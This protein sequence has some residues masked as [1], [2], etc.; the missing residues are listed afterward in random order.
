MYFLE[1]SISLQQ[2]Q[3]LLVFP[4]KID[5]VEKKLSFLMNTKQ[6]KKS[7]FLYET[8]MYFVFSLEKGNL[9]LRQ[10]MIVIL[11]ESSKAI[12]KHMKQAASDPQAAQINLMHN[13]NTELSPS[14]FQRKQKKP[15]KSRQDINKECYNEENKEKECHKSIRNIII[16]QMQAMKDVQN[17]VIH[18]I[19]RDSDVQLVNTNEE[20]VTNMTFQ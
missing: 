9:S 7:T 15:F 8:E 19:L 16:K 1:S 14:K 18:N 6:D 11:M 13:K 2:N 20:I 17:V 10:S 5:S 12:A 4:V 3:F